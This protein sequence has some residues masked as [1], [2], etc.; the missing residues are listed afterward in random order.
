MSYN[1]FDKRMKSYEHEFSNKLNVEKPTIVRIDGKNFSK[2]TKGLEKPG[3]KRL[4]KL[5][6][7]ITEYLIKEYAANCGFTQSDEITIVWD[8][9]SQLPFDGKVQKISSIFASIATAH[10]MQHNDIATHQKM[11]MFDARCYN[12]PSRT[13]AIN[14]LIWRQQDCYRNSIQGLAQC[15]FSHNQLHRKKCREQLQM[16]Q[17]KNVNWGYCPDWY[18]YGTFVTRGIEMRKL[19]VAELNTLPEKHLARQNPEILIERHSIR[20]YH[21][22]A[23]HYYEN[24]EGIVFEGASPKIECKKC[25]ALNKGCCNV[26]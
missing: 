7:D 3:S 2:W 25:G 1:D 15:Y 11:T 8:A 10:F 26:T 22:E 6:V 16:L 13:E 17:E 14:C 23:L 19:T 12:V 4:H 5:L 18:K 21:L 24:K 20:N 9:L